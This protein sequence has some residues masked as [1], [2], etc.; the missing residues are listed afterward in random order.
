MKKIWLLTSLLLAALFLSA[1]TPDNTADSIARADSLEMAEVQWMLDSIN[2]S[3]VYDTG[4][5]MLGKNLATLIVPAGFKY[6][7][8]RQ[9][10]DILV[11]LWANPPQ[12][13]SLGMLFPIQYGPADYSSWAVDISFVEEGYVSDEEANEMDFDEIE[14]DMLETAVETSNER[15]DAGYGKMQ[16]L[17]WAKQP[18]YDSKNKKLHWAMKFDIGQ[19]GVYSLNYNI[20][21]LGRRGYLMLNIIGSVDQLAEIEP[22]IEGILASVN[23]NETHSYADFDPEYD[24]VAAYGIGALVAGK[25]LA[26]AGF[27]VAIVKFWKVIALG[28]VAAGAAIKKFF[29]GESAA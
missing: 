2:N 22:H 6:V 27:W 16:F 20:R 4:K 25:L 21:M 14:K 1:S 28:A 29:T 7:S 24:K 8:G 11:K 9:A 12:S 5:V 17:G 15:E 10:D 19:E 18:F 26:K 23:F 3:Y 13:G